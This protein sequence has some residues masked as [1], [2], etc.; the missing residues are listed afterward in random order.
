MTRRNVTDEQ[1]GQFC[2]RIGEVARRVDEG[3]IPFNETMVALQRIIETVISTEMT[4]AGRTTEM[5][6]AGR[7]YDILGFL[8]GDEK[9]VKGDVMV[10]RAK[11]MDAN[12]GEEDARYIL[13]HQDEIPVALRDKV[14]FVFTYWRHPDG[15]EHV[16][17]VCW[18]C[19][20]WV[21]DWRWLSWR[22]S[23]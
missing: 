16:C 20:R 4:I 3:T 5:T 15:P 13:E 8:R 2:K 12:L 1:Y 14:A 22:S 17:F 18:F 10:A 19:N 6:I 23:P 11:E 21:K 7:T 9:Y